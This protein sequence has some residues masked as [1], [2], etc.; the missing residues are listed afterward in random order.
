[1]M[2]PNLVDTRTTDLSMVRCCISS[3]EVQSTDQRLEVNSDHQGGTS[4][5]KHKIVLL[6]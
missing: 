1:M 3:T 5:A 4:Y 6:L 2:P